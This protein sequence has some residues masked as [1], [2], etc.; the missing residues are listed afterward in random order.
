MIAYVDAF[1]HQFGVEVICRV[2]RATDGEF[3]TA[4]GC[5]AAKVRPLSDRDL[6]DRELVPVIE[7]LHAVNYSVYGRRKMWHALRREGWDIGRDQCARLMKI[8]G[9][10]GVRRGRKPLTTIASKHPDERLDLVDRDFTA[11]APNRL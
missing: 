8:A 10:S 5:W 3:I 7:R 9:L 6:R 4:R 1:R 2:L 11:L